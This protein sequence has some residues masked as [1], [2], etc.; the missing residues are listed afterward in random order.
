MFVNALNLPERNNRIVHF[1]G[2]PRQYRANCKPEIFKISET[3]T[4]GKRL[5]MEV[6]AYRIF[7]AQL[8]NYPYQQ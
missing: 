5:Q 6:L 7:N 2:S 8:F 3:S 4:L 1:S